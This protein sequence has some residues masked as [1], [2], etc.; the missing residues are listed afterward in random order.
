MGTYLGN[1]V[2][3]ERQKVRA[4]QPRRKKTTGKDKEKDFPSELAIGSG[5]LKRDS[6]SIETALA[7]TAS[8]L[9][10]LLHETK[11]KTD[12]RAMSPCDHK[13]GRQKEQKLKE[14]RTKT[15]NVYFYL[16]LRKPDTILVT[17]IPLFLM[18]YRAD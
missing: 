7:T 15:S 17:V 3:R 1:Y 12:L 2:E 5:W 16:K 8:G 13:P 9:M 10:R 11:Q 14:G 4:G 6:R 18:A